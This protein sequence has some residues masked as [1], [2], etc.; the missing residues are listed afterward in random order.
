MAN[1][2]ASRPRLLLVED[3]LL[4]RETIILMLEDDYEVVHEASVADALRRLGAPG[5]LPA[6]VL[7]LDCLLPDGKVS[8]VLAVADQ[9]S[10]PVVLISGDT[11]M[12]E[13]LGPD[14]L[15]LPKPFSQ[16]SLLSV[17]DSARG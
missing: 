7:L 6:D 9:L 11:R 1:E 17:L 2:L 12:N 10:I 16:A 3:D 13:T 4:V 8:V 5:A 15:F 14:R